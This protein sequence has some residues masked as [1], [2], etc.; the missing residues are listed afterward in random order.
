M[1]APGLLEHARSQATMVSVDQSSTAT[2]RMLELELRIAWPSAT[3]NTPAEAGLNKLWSMSEPIG[4]FLKLAAQWAAL[5]HVDL[6]VTHG[7]PR[8]C[9]PQAGAAQVPSFMLSTARRL[10]HVASAGSSMG[11]ASARSTASRV[12]KKVEL[13]KL[14]HA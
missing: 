12:M 1:H 8:V 6:M 7:A 11:R 14:L 2:H 13:A 3:D 9:P 10:R 4:S 5:H